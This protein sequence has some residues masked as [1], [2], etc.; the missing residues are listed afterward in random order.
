MA[1]LNSPHRAGQKRLRHGSS[2][3]ADVM[4]A[5]TFQQ[6]HWVASCFSICWSQQ[7]WSHL[8]SGTKRP[9]TA[10]SWV[11]CAMHR[12]TYPDFAAVRYV[13][14]AVDPATTG[15]RHN[16]HA[17]VAPPVVPWIKFRRCRSR[18]DLIRSRHRCLRSLA[19]DLPEWGRY[20][21]PT[22]TSFNSR[23]ISTSSL[24]KRLHSPSLA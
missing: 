5:R 13:N 22:S 2:G 6:E 12:W 7:L 4:G 1:Y 10:L 3:G 16:I 17:D 8:T 20:K 14:L 18:F 15:R 24:L 9:L 11:F 23:M 21:L 19:G